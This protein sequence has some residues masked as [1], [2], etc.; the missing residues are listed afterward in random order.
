LNVFL[1]RGQTHNQSSYFSVQRVSWNARGVSALSGLDVLSGVGH[2]LWLYQ[3]FQ[4]V[5][6]C[7]DADQLALVRNRKAYD[8]LLRHDL[9]FEPGRDVLYRKLQAAISTG[10]FGASSTLEF[11]LTILD[12]LD[13]LVFSMLTA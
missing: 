2:E 9:P 4:D 11:R 6:S 3:D 8:V 5:A 1:L 10:P 7:D 12:S 13:N